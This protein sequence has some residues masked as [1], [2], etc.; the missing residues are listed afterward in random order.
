MLSTA[1]AATAVEPSPFVGFEV[2][3]MT[4]GRNPYVQVPAEV[5]KAVLPWSQAGRVPVELKAGERVIRTSLV[6]MAGGRQRLYL[7]GGMRAALGVGVGERVALLLRALPQEKV[8]TPADVGEELERQN[9]LSV[10]ESLSPSHRREYLRWIDD[11][12]TPE[13]RRRRLAST[14]EELASRRA[15]TELRA[16]EAPA[17]QPV[18]GKMGPVALNSAAVGP[19]ASRPVVDRP[20]WVCPRCGQA[21]VNRNQFHS[22]ARYDLE[23]PFH[24][25]AA[26]VRELFEALRHMIEVN[27]PVTLVPYRDRVGFMVRVRFAGATPRQRWLEVSFWLTRRLDSPRL[28]KVETLMPRV[29]IH[30]LRL[31][32]PEELDEELSGLAG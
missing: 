16:A 27:G 12:R 17:E 19:A 31:A 11:A 15:K 28:R 32:S 14:I 4:T 26:S 18:A 3:V 9:L 10:F 23:E 5:T 29:H 7:N 2:L 25:K 30:T 24:G 8:S 21:F 20:L 22:C 1:G 13:T 6:P